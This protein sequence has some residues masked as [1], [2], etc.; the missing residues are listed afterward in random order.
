VGGGDE[1]DWEVGHHG[2]G[3]VIEI[4]TVRLR[5]YEVDL[6]EPCSS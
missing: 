3:E 1:E 4:K 6:D 5:L 2:E